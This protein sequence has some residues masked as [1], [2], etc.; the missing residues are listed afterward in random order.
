MKIKK[1]SKNDL[2]KVVSIHKSSFHGF[3]LTELGDDFLELYYHCILKH[4][5]GLLIGYFKDDAL[6]GFCAA[7]KQSSGFNSGLVKKN[8]FSFSSFA[9]GL[10]F[11]KPTALVRLFMNLTKSSTNI[12]DAADYA[13]LMSICVV[14]SVQSSG[15]GTKLMDH[16]ENE[17]QSNGCFKLSLTTDFENN[18]NVI[19]FYKKLGYSVYYEFT[20]FPKRKMYR[21]IKKLH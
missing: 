21:L 16:L 7:T 10:I 8:L 3:F 9:L 1:I 20:S 19:S 18:E 5:N 2:G 17:L 4:K 6:L 13:E 15:I 14:K 12:N 11:K